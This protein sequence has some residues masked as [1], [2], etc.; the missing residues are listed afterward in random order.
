V[1][2]SMLTEGWDANNVTHILG[3]RAFGT[4]L[5]CEQVIG[6]AL[7]RL[8]YEIDPET[9]LYP[10]E[11][12]DIMGIDGLNF[13]DQ[14]RTAPP[15]PPREVV[16]VRAVSPERDA[17]EITFP[18]VEGYRVDLAD[19]DIVADFTG[20]EPYVLTPEK[21]GAA[22]VT[23][24]GIVGEPEHITL[25][26][27]GAIRPSTIAT[28]LASYLVMQK[29][30]DANER[31]KMHL[32]PK[33]KMIV[34]A[35]LD[36][37]LLQC[38]GGTQPAQILYKQLTDE[39]CD[40]ILGALADQPKGEPILRAVLDPYMPMG[41][42]L[43]VNFNTSKATRFW[44]RP[45]RSHL[46]WIIT[47]S[48]WEADLATIIESDPR[49]LSYA[50]NHNLGFEVPYLMDGEPRR[51]LP[52]FLIRLDAPEPTTLVVEVKGFRGHDAM[53]K[54]GTMRGKWIPSV[55]RLGTYGRWGFAELRAAHDFRPDFDAAVKALLNESVSA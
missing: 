12:A 32:F 51:Y 17:L 50:K 46:N 14:P 37:G 8:V 55:N 34:R 15:Q 48:D 29:L 28:K 35:W 31:P 13:A 11:Y 30:R 21:V 16:Q 47:D 23:M 24:Q 41:S 26:H 43:G 39:A 22:E 52:D 6:R 3:L 45:D 49:V 25:K 4:Q 10:T 36:A 20:M 27:L 1:S 38:K 18:R 53:L 5:I 33:A 9:G 7:R 40:L 19:E 54:A 44:P 42:T 2:V